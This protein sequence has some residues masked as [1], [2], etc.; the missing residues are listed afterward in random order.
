MKLADS[1]VD[2]EPDLDLSPAFHDEVEEHDEVDEGK[3]GCGGVEWQQ[4]V[5]KKP[6]TSN[7]QLHELAREIRGVEKRRGK[8]LVVVQYEAIFRKWE[9]ASLPFLRPGHDYF[10]EFLAKL[11]CVTVPKGETL[12]A[13]FE[14]AQLRKPPFKVSLVPNDGVRLFASLCRELNEMSGGQPIMLHQESIAKLFG[15]SH[16]RTIGNW[17]S[18]LKTIEILKLAEPAVR[19]HQAARYSYVA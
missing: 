15:H 4:Y 10:T 5:L 13:A 9:A 16:W 18:A 2:D 12:L 6:Q 14:R 8:K 7:K 11:N 3:D 17:I 1:W 19:E